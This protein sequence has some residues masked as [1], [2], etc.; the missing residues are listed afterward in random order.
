MGRFA[1][2]HA[3]AYADILANGVA[4]TFT[5]A[6]R[7][8]TPATDTFGTAVTSTVTGAALRVRGDAKTYREMQLTQSGLVTLL[9]APTTYGDLPELGSTVTWEG[10]TQTVVAVNPVSPDG[11]AIIARVVLAP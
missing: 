8:H 7:T 5:T 4:V 9:F 3:G 6:T 1:A 2:E 10:Q 11:F